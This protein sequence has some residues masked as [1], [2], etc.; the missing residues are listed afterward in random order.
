MTDVSRSSAARRVGCVIK[1]ERL[2][3]IRSVSKWSSFFC[4]QAQ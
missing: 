2:L 4:T 1:E 3:I